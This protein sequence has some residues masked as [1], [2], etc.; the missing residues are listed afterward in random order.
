MF[1]P[2]CLSSLD[3][4]RHRQGETQ[5]EPC[6]RLAVA[7]GFCGRRCAGPVPPAPERS[8]EVPRVSVRVCVYL[9][10]RDVCPPADAMFVSCSTGLPFV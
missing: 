4:R 8:S 5:R 3:Q 2:W 10:H 7:R 6:R 9:R 1:R